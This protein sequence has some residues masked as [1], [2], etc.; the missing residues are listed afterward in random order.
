MCLT[1]A[2]IGMAL[3]TRNGSA[4]QSCSSLVIHPRFCQPSISPSFG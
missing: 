4:G 2:S 1:E 3:A